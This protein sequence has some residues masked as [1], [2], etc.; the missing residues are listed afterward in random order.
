M[1]CFILLGTLFISSLSQPNLENSLLEYF[2]TNITQDG[3][4]LDR[5]SNKNVVSVAAT[6]FGMYAYGVGY[7]QG[8]L[9]KAIAS[10]RIKKAFRTTIKQNPHRNRNWLTHWS[11]E[12]GNL[13][14]NK[15]I[16]TIDSAIFYLGAQRAAFLLDDKDF[17]KEVQNE[18]NKV[19]VAWLMKGQYIRHGFTWDDNGNVNFLDVVWDNYSEGVIIYRLFNIPYTPKETKFD[20]PLFAY[21]YPLCFFDEPLMIVNL[22]NAIAFQQEK[23]SGYWAHTA[24][25]T[26]FKGYQAFDA[27][28]ISPLARTVVTS[29]LKLP[30]DDTFPAKSD[31]NSSGNL[32]VLSKNHLTG[33]ESREKIAIDIGC[34]YILLWKGNLND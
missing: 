14:F 28:T 8:R 17:I 20:L 25:E 2:N 24:G 26:E 5:E 34:A 27:D 6:G 11:D 12:L 10:Y 15:E 18:I 9:N 22:K 16:S 32:C 1:S 29:Y 19:D 4:I 13:I 33:W 31:L 21:Y 7:Q 30:P 3:R 23:Y